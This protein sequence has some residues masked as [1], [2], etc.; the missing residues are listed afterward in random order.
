[1][2]P[3]TPEQYK[4]SRAVWENEVKIL[5]QMNSLREPRIVHFYTAFRREG[6]DFQSH[7]LMFEFASGGNLRQLWKKVSRPRLTPELGQDTVDQLLGL[8]NALKAAHDPLMSQPGQPRFRHGDLKP[9]NI[10]WFDEHDFASNGSRIGTLKIADWGLAKQH[11]VL[12]EL[13]TTSTKTP[14]GTGLYEPPE[15]VTGDLVN[16][17]SLAPGAT[18]KRRSRLCDIWAMGCIILE[19]LIWLMYGWEELQ[20]FYQSL[21]VFKAGNHARFFQIRQKD[22]IETAHVHEVVLHWMDHMA[23]DPAFKGPETALEALLDMVRE[24]LLVVKLP[25]RLAT[26]LEEGITNALPTRS[27]PD[28][29]LR[30]QLLPGK[31]SPEDAS[32]DADQAYRGPIVKVEDHSEPS[33]PAANTKLRPEIRPFSAIKSSGGGM[34]RALAGGFQDQMLLISGEEHPNSYWAMKSRGHPP[35]Q[36]LP[37]GVQS[38]KSSLMPD[39]RLGTDVTQVM[40]TGVKR[41]RKRF[42][43]CI[44]LLC[45]QA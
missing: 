3:P 5:Q 19:F 4:N 13:R 39:A 21:G 38:G 45:L 17:Q 14:A 24:R 7:Y 42:L 2:Q 26:K 18:I 43:P 35:S 6:S 29:Q 1:M 32:A 27:P 9:E 22:G 23:R 20:K 15:E 36:A 25:Q 33:P 34:E 30:N 10:L 31:K 28:H 44:L 41:V 40:M 11:L 16:R 8:A 37:K 12:T